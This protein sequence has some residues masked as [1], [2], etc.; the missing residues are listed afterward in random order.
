MRRV[1]S[2]LSVLAFLILALLATA[3]PREAQAN[4]DSVR[5]IDLVQTPGAIWPQRHSLTPGH[6]IFRVRNDGDD[7][8]VTLRLS[9]IEADGS[10][11]A[12]ITTL[13][14]PL[15]DGQVAETFVVTLA[16]GRYTYRSPDNPTPHY[17]IDVD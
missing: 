1:F 7:H 14:P 15:L 2:S 5:V 8:G 4:G 13:Q 17:F 16:S 3:P 6:Y 9:R 11:G 12:L 10:V